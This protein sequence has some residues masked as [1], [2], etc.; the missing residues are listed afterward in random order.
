MVLLL[1]TYGYG[2]MRALRLDVVMG[3]MITENAGSNKHPPNKT[4]K[5]EQSGRRLQFTKP[6]PPP[7]A[8]FSLCSPLSVVS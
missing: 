6:S 1:I 5:L 2:P 7:V 3:E 8:W 4:I